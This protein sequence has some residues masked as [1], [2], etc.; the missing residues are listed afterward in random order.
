MRK[1]KKVL[2]II[3]AV[4][5][6]CTAVP[7]SFVGATAEGSADADASLVLN[8]PMASLLVTDITR[9]AYQ[10]NSMKAPSGN[11]SVIV[12]STPSGIPYLSATAGKYAYA[13]ETPDATKIVFTPGVALDEIPVL[14][15]TNSTIRW[16]GPVE[17]NGTYTWTLSSGTA[18]AGSTLLFNVSYKYSDY[19]EV[20]G[21]TY[22]RTYT[23]SGTSYVEPIATPAGLF[24][25]KRTYANYGVGSS[26][27]NRSYLATYLLGKN[28][29]GSIYNDGTPDGSV[30][31]SSSAFSTGSP[32]TDE[33]GM[34]QSMSDSDS[35]RNYNVAFG[36]DTNRPLTTVYY[37]RSINST[38]SD[39][40]LRAVTLIMN[41]A[42]ESDEAVTVTMKETYVLDGVVRTGEKSSDD[43]DVTSDSTKLAELNISKPTTSIK[44]VGANFIQYFSGPGPAAN[45]NNAYYTIVFHYQTA[46]GWTDVRV[47][48]THSVRVVSYDKGALRTLVE[49]VQINDPTVKTTELPVGD[50]KGYNP[51]SW[52]YATGWESFRSALETA[53][54]CL[55][56]ADVT[57]SEINS[58]Y[59]NLSAKYDELVMESADYT[60]AD[61]A[62]ELGMSKNPDYY[63]YSS[64]SKL[65]TAL[66][67]YRRDYSALYQPAVDKMEIDIKTAISKLEERYADYSALEDLLLTVNDYVYSAQSDYL[68]EP[69]E[70]YSGW[71]T[72]VAVLTNAGCIYDELD[73]F[74]VEDMLPISEQSKVDGYVVLIQRA[75]NGIGM[76]G[77]DY[78]EANKAEKAYRA[79]NVNCVVDSVA[80]PLK[81]AYNTL[82]GLHN[83]DITHQAEIDRAT[84]TLNNLLKQVK[85][86]PANITAA[87]Q[88]I[89][90]AN[91]LDREAYG[92]FSGV[93]AAIENLRSK[94]SLDI[95][96]QSEIDN[97]VLALQS[98]ID[99]LTA[100]SADYTA[101]DEALDAVAAK[102]REVLEAYEDSYGFTADVFYANWSSVTTAVNSVIRGLDANHQAQV[103]N[104]AAAI[105]GALDNLAESEAD[106]TGVNGLKTTAN[107]LYLN[108]SSLYTVESRAALLDVQTNI[109]N[110]LPISQQAT[111]DGYAD[112]IQQAIDNLKYLPAS[113]TNVETQKALANEKIKA[114]EDFTKAHPGYT[115][116][117]PE[118]LVAVEIAMAEVVEGLDIREQTRVNGFATGISTAISNLKYAPADY[119]E[120]NLALA[121]VPKDLSLY[122]S[123][124]VAALNAAI[125]VDY[126]YTADKQATVDNYVSKINTAIGKLKYKSASY[127]NVDNALARVPSD[128]TLYTADSWQALQEQVNAVVRGLDI[129]QQSRVDQMAENINTA[130][131]FLA[132]KGADYTA[133]NNAKALVP[134]DLT[135]YKQDSVAALQTVLDAVN[136]YCNVTQQATVDG[137]AAAITK[138]VSELV[139]LDGDYTAL[140]EALAAADEK[141][142][143]GF[144]TDESVAVLN[145]EIAKV[146]TGLSKLRQDDI[147]L[148]TDNIVKA[149]KELALK[150]ADYTELQKILNLL[151]NSS[152]EI[153]TITYTN[154]D[155]VMS[156][157]SS[158]RAESVKMNVTA[159]RQSEVNT[160]VST[161]QGYIDMLEEYVPVVESFSFVSD[162]THN[163]TFKEVDDVKYAFGFALKLAK[164]NVDAYFD[165]EN[166]HVEIDYSNSRYLGTGSVIHVISD[167]TGEEIDSYVVV[168]Y[169]D[170]DGNGSVTTDD[171]DLIYDQYFGTDAELSY[172][173][174]LA[175]N[176][177]GSKKRITLDTDDVDA[178][179]AVDFGSCYI[180][181]LTGDVMEY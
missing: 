163:A 155:D 86:K 134:S 15:C 122:T 2:S 67:N 108:G 59:N 55:E 18:F 113:Y 66:D 49:N 148:W 156:L 80:E 173:S 158:Y 75:L 71:S 141:I 57:Q 33:Y 68:K 14:S 34:M 5:L 125:K 54:S 70:V 137:Y 79:V 149:T 13:G 111:V 98:A 140:N 36:A 85:Y 26:T 20:T 30:N 43:L 154:F 132:Y 9:V 35:S 73:G 100:N 44:N 130:I 6:V 109:E 161:L 93:D 7:M 77:A 64:W 40:N 121:N 107:N 37:D 12:K 138:A 3:L 110:N 114:D 27:Q 90:Y 61:A 32:W 123:I 1:I 136:Y 157:I 103:D 8:R 159:D 181:Q 115:L 170:V 82:F 63:T 41:K 139:P 89:E 116:Y 56:R 83:L 150:L 88:K 50:F 135:L 169:G 117:T 48:H 101:V 174:K 120:V 76:A 99:R 133:V 22:T 104:Y 164:K 153:Y 175:G 102:E 25:T 72:L 152:S 128:S 87:E 176:V 45:N 166:V 17:S 23:T 118:S 21:R 65:K 4:A 179:K 11:N 97:A 29:Y 24:T 81:A 124:S 47:A 129:T 78:T 171:A 160:M 53:K 106:Y 39:L 19:N 16:T 143:T 42:S 60:Y 119:T 62:Y 105:N 146:Q 92:D 131:G 177:S 94:L 142:K 126:T 112:A 46:A 151:D 95:R 165:C 28:T 84:A 38:L 178:L 168:I 144:Y 31:F 162:E 167:A 96:Y 58:A 74:V 172:E 127:T 69:E 145:G 147:D 180:D 10:T 51:Q 52:Y 91:S